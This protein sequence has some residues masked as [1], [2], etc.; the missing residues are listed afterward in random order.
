MNNN[1]MVHFPVMDRSG[2]RVSSA[3]LFTR[4]QRKKLSKA[5][6]I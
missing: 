6:Q 5:A 4:E 2:L 3:N 1:Y